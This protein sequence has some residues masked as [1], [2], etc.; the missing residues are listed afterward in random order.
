MENEQRPT[1]HETEDQNLSA[2]FLRIE[3]LLAEQS[4]DIQKETRFGRAFVSLMPENIQVP[5]NKPQAR[6]I[7]IYLR[8][9]KPEKTE[10]HIKLHSN[11]SFEM[12][13]QKG[14]AQTGEQIEPPFSL[15]EVLGEI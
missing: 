3:A 5:T 7:D 13:A 6:Y 12:S 15:S 1:P 11:G 14:W 2:E 9:P 8:S 10:T 4:V